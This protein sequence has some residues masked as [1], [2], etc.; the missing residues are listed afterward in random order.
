MHADRRQ[1]GEPAEVDRRL[2]MAGAHEHAAILGDQRKDVAGA[3][4]IAGA[5]IAVGER[6][7]RVGALLGRD[8]GRQPVP[9][10][11]RDREG[12]AER[13]VVL[14]PPSDRGAGAAPRRRVSGAQ[15]MPQVLRMMNAIFSGVQ[16]EAAT[17][18]SPSFSRS[19]SSVTTTISPRAKASMASA[20]RIRP[21]GHSRAAM[22]AP[23]PTWPRWR[24]KWSANAGDHRLAD[25]HGADADAGVVPALGDDLGLLAGAVDRPA[26]RQDRRGRLDGEARD[27]RLAGRDA[28]E[29]AA[30][31][32]GQEARRPSL[33][34]R[35][36]SAFSSPVS[37]AAREAVADLDALDG[38]D[39]HQRA[40]RAR[41][42]ACRRP[43]RRARPARPRRRPRSPRRPRSRPCAG[44]RDSPPRRRRPS[45]SGQKNG[46]RSTSSQSQSA[47]SIAV[48]PIC[49]SA[50]R[51]R[52]RRRAPCG[53]SPPAATR[54]AVS[55]AD[56][57]PAAA[58]V[59]DAVF[60][61][62]RCS[63][64]GRAGNLSRDLAI[65]LRALVDVAGSSARSA[66]RW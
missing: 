42:R 59:A 5:H 38:V 64:R 27:D 53:R 21:S 40:R 34:M 8:A 37:A 10:V 18:R 50:P 29:D 58:V 62:R 20:T 31:V 23:A 63:R 22:A 49:T 24:R 11:D 52:A 28:A 6:A 7:H 57:R 15:T 36:S 3:D 54:A 19:S 44:R 47:R 17:I 13:R 60:E 66:C 65:V 16:S 14:P 1:P 39:R 45:A 26:R 9:D 46:F 12:G 30:G 2:G 61:R 48:R 41:R 4:E 43:A 55:R 35:I 33:P 51:M 25:R 56:E 32:V